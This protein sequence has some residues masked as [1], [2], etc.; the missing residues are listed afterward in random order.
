M[1]DRISLPHLL[2]QLLCDAQKLYGPR[3]DPSFTVDIETF[4]PVG[5][6]AHASMRQPDLTKRRYV[7]YV[8]M[9]TV[10]TNLGTASFAIG[11]EVIHVLS[12]V[13][14][15]WTTFAEE[16]LGQVF[17]F[18]SAARRGHWEI[19]PRISSPY[20]RAEWLV[21][22]LLRI[23]PTAIKRVREVEPCLSKVTVD[24]LLVQCPNLDRR[25]AQQLTTRFPE[26]EDNVSQPR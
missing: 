7:I 15:P 6:V 18:D 11:H 9:G 17:A 24:Q 22:Q 4:A 16:G 1:S 26:G 8:P 21:S 2:Y 10:E 12:C 3:L 23:D 13:G 25:I 20:W 19:S 14:Q 5:R